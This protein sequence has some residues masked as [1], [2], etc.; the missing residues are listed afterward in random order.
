MS[1][2]AEVLVVEVSDFRF[3]SNSFASFEFLWRLDRSLDKS[4]GSLQ[5]ELAASRSA[6]ELGSGSGD[7]K[8]RKKMFMVIGINTAFSSR[9]RRDSVRETWMPQGIRI[10]VGLVVRLADVISSYVFVI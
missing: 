6:M 4:I 3:C 5:T 7:Q 1:V 8:V 10:L 2:M 9:K